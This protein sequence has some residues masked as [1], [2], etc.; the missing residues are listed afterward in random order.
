MNA[1][2]SG[3]AFALILSVKVDRIRRVE[4]EIRRVFELPYRDTFASIDTSVL[5]QRRSVLFQLTFGHLTNTGITDES[6]VAFIAL[7]GPWLGAVEGTAAM[8]TARI[9][10][11]LITVTTGEADVAAAFVG[12]FTPAVLALG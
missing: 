2:K 8:L 10:N 6:F 9:W 11:A 5:D 1:P 4:S 12:R 3:Q 7:T